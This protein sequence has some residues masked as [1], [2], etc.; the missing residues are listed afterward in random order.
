MLSGLQY[1]KIVLSFMLVQGLHRDKNR[2]R[3]AILL[4][5][6]NSFYFSKALATHFSDIALNPRPFTDMSISL[7]ANSYFL[8][9]SFCW[10]SVFAAFF[11][12]LHSPSKNPIFCLSNLSKVHLLLH[13]QT[14]SI[15]IAGGFFFKIHFFSCLLGPLYVVKYL[16]NLAPF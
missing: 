10:G 6:S 1:C 13:H 15:L 3:Q 12:C 8:E 14:F 11:L 7:K 9:T 4:R 5:R 16:A 2:R